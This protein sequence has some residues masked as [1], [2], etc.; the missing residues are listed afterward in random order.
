MY[1]KKFPLSLSLKLEKK[2]YGNKDSLAFF[3][4]LLPEGEARNSIERIQKIKGV[5]EFLAEYGLDCAGAI[6]IS[7]NENFK[8]PAAIAELIPIDEKKIYQA[9]DEKKSVLEGALAVKDFKLYMSLSL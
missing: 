8:A 9:L 3:E 5:F 4:N 7:A 1:E 6:I 2:I